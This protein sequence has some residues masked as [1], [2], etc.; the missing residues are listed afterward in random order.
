MISF[1]EAFKHVAQISPLCSEKIDL[2][3]GS[4]R[5]VAD[6]LISTIDCPSLDVSLK[7][8]FAVISSDLKNASP[9]NLITL[10]LIGMVT[11]GER[12]EGEIKSGQ[13]LRILSGA[14]IP[15]GA[16]A[17][18]SEEFTSQSNRLI[19]AFNDAGP[20]RNILSA[21]S[22]VK[23]GKILV[24]KG[25]TLYPP[26]IGLLAAAGFTKIPVIKRPR[27][28]ILAT[29]DEVIAPGE[30]LLVGK[31]Y[32]SNLVTLAA[33]C[34]LFGFDPKTRVVK[35]NE[36]TIRQSITDLLG[37]CDALLTS[38]GAWSG[39]HDLVVKILAELGW[40]KVFHRVRMGPGKAVGFGHLENK[41]VFC[42]PGGPP[43]NHMAFLQLALPGLQKMAGSTKP[44]L[45]L[46][47]VRIGESI[48]GQKDWTQFIHGTINEESGEFEFYP[49]RQISRLQMLSNTEGIVKIPE[50]QTSLKKGDFT[51]VQKLFW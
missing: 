47:K 15:Q 51:L 45:P 7:D 4:G 12:W 14:P 23:A 21:G 34:Q 19:M 50:G 48:S 9:D 2:S 13:A 29:G 8:G 3:F 32:A 10:Q 26:K 28:A 40:Q 17:V 16:D 31:L 44:G 41:P 27:V 43:S 18:I 30:P 49:I 20:G 36:I 11:A 37:E 22:D 42:L 1:A 35:D 39:E 5:V 6:D 25:T 33:W 38:G 46:Q 24:P